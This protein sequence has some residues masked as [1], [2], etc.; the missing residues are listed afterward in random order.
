[1]HSF[2][3]DWGV[4]VIKDCCD[5]PFCHWN[6]LSSFAFG[7]HLFSL[8]FLI[9]CARVSVFVYLGAWKVDC[10]ILLCLYMYI[11]NTYFDFCFLSCT[12]CDDQ[13]MTICR[14]SP[15]V[16]VFIDRCVC[17]VHFH[18]NISILL[19]SDYIPVTHWP[20]TL[21]RPSS[22]VT[23]SWPKHW[24]IESLVSSGSHQQSS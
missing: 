24:R 18:G 11:R 21:I 4:H 6:P 3:Y 23:R 20:L 7:L 17:G 9:V 12:V 8:P 2:S 15:V 19:S 14:L 16:D 22:L 13:V 5:Q 1:M 10:N